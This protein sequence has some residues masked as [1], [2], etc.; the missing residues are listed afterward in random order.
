MNIKKLVS[1]ASALTIAASAFAGLAVT[2]S[3]AT[4]TLYERGTTAWA[5]A[6]ATTWGGSSTVDT[7]YGL[8]TTGTNSDNEAKYTITP[9]ANSV[10]T[11]D[12]Y[13][14]GMSNTGRY[15]SNGC[16]SY[17]R[18]G[19]I[20][21]CQ[22]DQDKASGYTLTGDITGVTT[23]T[24]P[25]GY[26]DYDVSTKNY[27]VIHIEV[28]TATNTLNSLTVKSSADLT[29]DLL[30]LSDVALT[31]ADY[32]TIATGFK[33][34]ASHSTAHN[35]YLKSL[36]ITE[37]TQEVQT[38]QYTVK[39]V[40]AD[41]TVLALDT[42]STVVGTTPTLTYEDITNESGKYRYVSDDVA[43]IGGVADDDSTVYT[44]T[45]EAVPTYVASVNA[46]ADDSTIGTYSNSAY[47]GEA[48]T[49]YYPKYIEKNGT[50]YVT[51]ANGAY[52]SYG[53]GFTAAGSADVTYTASDVAYAAE[54]ESL[55]ASHSWAADGAVP[56]RYSNGSAKRLYKD[57][58]VTL[59]GWTAERNSEVTVAL[60]ARNQSS[61]QAASISVYTVDA[62]GTLTDTG[63]DIGEWASAA[64]SE[65][66]ATVSVPAGSRIAI[67]NDTEY[68]SNLELDYAAITVVSVEPIT[69]TATNVGAFE[70]DAT[71]GTTGVATAF[72]AEMGDV[73]GTLSFTVTTTE[74][75]ARS[76]EGATTLTEANVVLGIIVN[77]LYDAGAT[78]VLTVVE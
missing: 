17:F 77:G 72:K 40:L 62:E 11:V 65:M 69:V 38:A 41:G 51:A 20:Y 78:G 26:R 39:R 6:D 14:V 67:Y 3:A 59:S 33:R 10:I 25:N 27:Y 21:I 32:T 60:W 5:D 16:A 57:S 48:V 37:T 18:F 75:L 53:K 28:D 34:G 70:D 63:I 56:V 50:Y 2:A 43:T 55:S 9:T 7:T 58:Y 19:N 29:T 64:Q 52:P 49:V 61:S 8:H 47:E 12:A 68:N 1:A 42:A 74:G 45:Y 23:F 46:V 36:T 30:S 31:G 76:F 54:I 44:L 73:T 4:N 24:G 35:E 15:F 71:L 13:W 66:T 22:N